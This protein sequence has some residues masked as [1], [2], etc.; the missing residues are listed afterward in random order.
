MSLDQM[1]DN[2]N[3]AFSRR[4]STKIARDI[5]SE[6]RSTMLILSRSRIAPI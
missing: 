5:R 3:M 1:V 6:I 4:I 2:G